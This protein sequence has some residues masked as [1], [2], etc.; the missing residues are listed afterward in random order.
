MFVPKKFKFKK[1]QKGVIPNSINSSNCVNQLVF[2][3][4]GLKAISFCRLN[5][6]Q[7][8]TIK[9]IITKQIKKTGRLIIHAFPNVS[10]S[11]KSVENRMGKGK[12]NV[13]HWIFKIKPGF[14][15]CE[16]VTD[17]VEIAK[18]ALTSVIKRIS[19]KVRIILN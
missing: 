19:L 8:E 15:F 5:S 13:D 1:Q 7:I 14:I 16:I 6:K 11:Q 17:Q 9:K 3:S 4:I 10:I 12:G 2:G 18:K